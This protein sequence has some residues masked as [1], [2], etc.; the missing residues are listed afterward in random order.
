GCVKRARGW[1][2]ARVVEG[3]GS[4]TGYAGKFASVLGMVRNGGSRCR[5]TVRCVV[6]AW[7]DKGGAAAPWTTASKGGRGVHL[8]C[9]T[10]HGLPDC[11][12][13]CLLLL[14]DTMSG[15]K[16]AGK[17]EQTGHGELRGTRSQVR[18]ASRTEPYH[19][20]SLY[21]PD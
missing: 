6:A 2:A 5:W 10:G 17:T 3:A 18:C 11:A 16:P 20:P 9:L 4:R 8:F 14:L 12:A 19:L 7:T 1:R 15:F 21:G 13:R